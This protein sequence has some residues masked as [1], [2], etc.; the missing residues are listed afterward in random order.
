MPIRCVPA[1]HGLW[2]FHHRGRG[3]IQ[4]QRRGGLHGHVHSHCNFQFI[5]CGKMNIFDK[6][7]FC[8]QGTAN[9][10]IPLI[11]GEN[12]GQHSKY[13]FLCVKIYLPD[14]AQKSKNIMNN[15]SMSTRRTPPPSTSPSRETLPPTGSG[16]SRSPRSSAQT[17][18]GLS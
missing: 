16:T 12:T 6:A 9:Q 1:A 15:Q 10:N 2:G 5:T 7:F 3:W 11:C 17:Q 8:L 4:P 18:T 13:F 14:F